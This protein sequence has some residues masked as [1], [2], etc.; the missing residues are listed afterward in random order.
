MTPYCF[1]V[2]LL[3][4]YNGQEGLLMLSKLLRDDNHQH[5]SKNGM[6]KQEAREDVRRLCEVF[7]PNTV[8]S[9]FDF[10]MD[11]Y[12][13]DSEEDDKNRTLKVIEM[14]G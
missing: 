6:A 5:I 3:A 14:Y 9:S 4:G 1:R 10:M 2:D 8:D 7:T 11:S 13:I 12:G